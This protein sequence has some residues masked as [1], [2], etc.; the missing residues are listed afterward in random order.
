MNPLQRARI[1]RILDKTAEYRMAQGGPGARDPYHYAAA[2][3]YEDGPMIAAE[4]S[5]P[6]EQ[7]TAA[8]VIAEVKRLMGARP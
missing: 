8:E 7:V 4:I 6:G 3:M 2:D 1:K 5:G